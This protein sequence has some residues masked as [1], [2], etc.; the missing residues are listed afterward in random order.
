MLLPKTKQFHPHFRQLVF[1]PHV[2]AVEGQLGPWVALVGN[3]TIRLFKSA[4]PLQ[5]VLYVEVL[6]QLLGLH[7]SDMRVFCQQPLNLPF[8]HLAL[9]IH[10]L[11]F[12]LK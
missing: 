2:V 8:K 6:G 7:L 9:R 5:V 1:E 11:R 3:G 10:S 4:S 12:V